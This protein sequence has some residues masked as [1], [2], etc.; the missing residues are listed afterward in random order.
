MI[1]ISGMVVGSYFWGCL[2]DT[3][4]RRIVLIAA[5][6]LDG[7]CGI[8]SSLTPYFSVFMLFRFFNGFG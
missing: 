3:K 2:A 8:A 7:I 5:L 4:G 1:N 6:L